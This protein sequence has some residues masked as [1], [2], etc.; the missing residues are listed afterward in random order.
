MIWYFK[1][2]YRK[3]EDRLF[4]RAHSNRRRDN[5]FKVKEVGIRM[6]IRKFFTM[7]VVN[8]LPR[9]VVDTPS[10]ETFVARLDGAL[11]NLV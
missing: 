6:G 10:L 8:W 7:N 4:V 11:T 3:D 1:G 2:A 5:G 9:G